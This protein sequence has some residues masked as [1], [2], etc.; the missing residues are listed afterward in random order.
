M[1]TQKNNNSKTIFQLLLSGQLKLL[2]NRLIEIVFPP[3]K[4]VNKTENNAPEVNEKPLEARRVEDE[5]QSE[6][7][8]KKIATDEII[9][10]TEKENR[11][12]EQ[13]AQKN[14][15]KKAIEVTD[16]PKHEK[17]PIL[18]LLKSMTS[19]NLFKLV[20]KYIKDDKLAE[21]LNI[22]SSTFD[23]VFEITW[24][25]LIERILSGDFDAGSEEHLAVINHF[26]TRPFTGEERRR[27]I[28]RG[29]IVYSKLLSK[30][31]E[32]IDN[33]SNIDIEKAAVVISEI[34][35]DQYQCSHGN[36]ESQMEKLQNN[37]RNLISRM[38]SSQR[39]TG[40]NELKIISVLKRCQA[41]M[42]AKINE[43]NNETDKR[44]TNDFLSAIQNE[45]ASYESKKSNY[46]AMINKTTEQEHQKSLRL[47][48]VSNSRIVELLAQKEDTEIK[49][50]FGAE[51]RRNELI[52]ELFSRLSGTISLANIKESSIFC[53][54]S[55][56]IFLV[57]KNKSIIEEELRRL[58][59]SDNEVKRASAHSL[60][61]TLYLPKC[62]D[63][64]LCHKII[65]DFLTDF[66]DSKSLLSREKY[67][68][69]S[70]KEQDYLKNALAPIVGDEK[71]DAY[72]SKYGYSFFV[73][74]INNYRFMTKS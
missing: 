74:F 23:N 53:L 30:L 61:Q 62:K 14:E 22:E 24:N 41:L 1:K 67:L 45:I 12:E 51:C 55:R 13:E 21:M 36:I 31:S 63:E 29:D 11:I 44:K 39:H 54:F 7:L 65:L 68:E 35:C 34:F 69:M 64:I 33:D 42:T 28:F 25:I 38:I 32:G 66:I 15:D 48:Q 18:D 49:T 6:E 10:S 2:F 50:Q 19:D 52:K 37:L 57:E 3:Q 72:S 27:Q 71:E 60:L 16:T 26:L 17:S 8:E 59:L 4:K 56:N 58:I 5:P 20:Q 46:I 73:K 9:A 40:G 43:M 70:K 47:N